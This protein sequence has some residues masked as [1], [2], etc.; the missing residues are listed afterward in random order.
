[1]SKLKEILTGWANLAL[2]QIDQLDEETKK[3]GERRASICNDCPIRKS[4]SCDNTQMLEATVDFMYGQ[5]HR[6]KGT[7]YSGCGCNLKA[8][9]LSPPSQCPV[10]K[11]EHMSTFIEN[12]NRYTV[13]HLPPLDIDKDATNRTSSSNESV[14]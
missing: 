5:E 8:K 14:Q 4:N 11:W 9:V 6:E 12:G 1:M 2:D 7:W 3:E 13:M 10:G